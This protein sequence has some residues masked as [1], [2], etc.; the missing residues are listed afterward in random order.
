M[1]ET[2]QKAAEQAVTERYEALLF[3]TSSRPVLRGTLQALARVACSGEFL[4]RGVASMTRMR[5][6][7]ISRRRDPLHLKTCAGRN[8]HM[9][10]FQHQQPMISLPRR[11]DSIPS[12]N[13]D[14][15]KPGVRLRASDA[16]APILGLAVGSAEA[17]AY[18]EEVRFSR[19]LPTKWHLR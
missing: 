16:S 1:S 10:V 13:R 4:R 12:R 9:V 3:L 8:L 6:R 5:T 19:S 7:F 2:D 15:Q 17:D 18:S 14:A 11:G